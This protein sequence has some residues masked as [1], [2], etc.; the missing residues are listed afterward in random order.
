[1]LS[2]KQSAEGS[3]VAYNAKL[4]VR[5]AQD[6]G[7]WLAWCLPLDVMTQARTKSKALESIQEAVE[8]WFESCIERGVLEKALHEVGF[9]NATEGNEVPQGASVVG[10]KTVSR[11]KAVQAAA[12]ASPSNTAM[13]DT[14]QAAFT[15][16]RKGKPRYIEVSIPAYIAAQYNVGDAVRAAR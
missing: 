8:G 14:V 15:R 2:R 10:V 12:T 1:M 16:P 11:S 6:G 3:V 4:E 7:D 9:I 5:L 13:M